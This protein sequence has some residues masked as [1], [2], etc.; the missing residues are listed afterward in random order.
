MSTHFW[1]YKKERS[2]WKEIFYRDES[3]RLSSHTL[4][5]QINHFCDVVLGKLKPK[6]SGNDGLQSDTRYSALANAWTISGQDEFSVGNESDEGVWS[7]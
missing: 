1:F 6:V 2:W 4:V 5:N 7:H 3:T